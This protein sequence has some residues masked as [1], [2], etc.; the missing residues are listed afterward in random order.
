MADRRLED[1]PELVAQ[2]ASIGAR[3]LSEK[4]GLSYAEIMHLFER[5]GAFRKSSGPEAPIPRF[6]DMIDE[7]IEAK[8][9]LAWS[10]DCDLKEESKQLRAWNLAVE[11]YAPT[12]SPDALAGICS[13][14]AA[15]LATHADALVTNGTCPGE[16]SWLDRSL[17]NLY[18]A[19]LLRLRV[20]PQGEA[21][22]SDLRPQDLSLLPDVRRE[23]LGLRS[24]SLQEFDAAFRGRS[25]AAAWAG[26]LQ[27]SSPSLTSAFL[28]LAQRLDHAFE[29]LANGEMVGGFTDFV[30]LAARIEYA[31]LFDDWH[32]V[33]QA[34][35][36]AG[37]FGTR[38][39]YQL[40]LGTGSQL[41]E[42]ALR[43]FMSTWRQRAAFLED[44]ERS[45]RRSLRALSRSREARAY[46]SLAQGYKVDE[47][48]QTIVM[49]ELPV[50]GG[51]QPRSHELEG[52]S[53]ESPVFVTLDAEQHCFVIGG[54]RLTYDKGQEK[55]GLI[56][57]TNRQGRILIDIVQNG[58]RTLVDED[59]LGPPSS[60]VKS[61]VQ[62]ACRQ[63]KIGVVEFDPK[64][65][66]VTP[67]LRF[68]ERTAQRVRSLAESA[69]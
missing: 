34:L 64:T 66:R 5:I 60:H 32:Q 14:G 21:A 16:G 2:V 24:A 55:P 63:A 56:R 19:T 68:D 38:G 28:R 27:R 65:Y 46:S 11:P 35:L 18:R 59:L 1:D 58:S 7:G 45:M 23:I 10:L 3:Q 6:P 43:H 42:R 4:H 54:I 29:P 48:A 52:V 49:W 67:R 37:A 20:E 41:V 40:R 8:V 62:D 51:M 17:A 33:R 9:A 50:I 22:R 30:R 12:S 53:S 47:S 26:V 13:N 25:P 61:A 57:P 31:F 44:R 69:N 39:Y 15:F 36:E